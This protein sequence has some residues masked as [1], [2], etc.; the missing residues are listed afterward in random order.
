L[1]PRAERKLMLHIRRPSAAKA[2]ALA[3]AAIRETFEETGL[4]LGTRRGQP[5]GAPEGAWSAFTAANILP[6]LSSM[7]FI[8]RAVTPPR[9]KRRFD[10]RFFT[11]DVS[12]IAHRIDGKVG[13]DFELTELVWLPLDGIKE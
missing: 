10:T 2:Q 3:L 8:A 9:R 5:S 11:A 1:D 6:D 4:L 7:H 13:A 12:A